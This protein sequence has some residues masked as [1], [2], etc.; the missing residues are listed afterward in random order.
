[1]FFEYP[2]AFEQKIFLPDTMMQK[3]A[4]LPRP[5]VFTNGCFDLLHRGH[6]TYLAQAKALGATLIVGVNCDASVRQLGKGQDRPIH[7]E[8]DRAAVLAA[9]ASTDVVIL[10]AEATPLNL[11]LMIQPD[12]LVKGGD[13]SIDHIVGSQ[14]VLAR[15]GRVYSIPFL[16]DTSTTATIQKIK[17]ESV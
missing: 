10:F 14:E 17:Q 4:Q 15:G 1:M 11:I 9:L 3:L 16:F 12:I 5:F 7:A 8:Q 13:W 6:T 2:P